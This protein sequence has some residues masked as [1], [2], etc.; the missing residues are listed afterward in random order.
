M[1]SAVA[2]TRRDFT[3]HTLLATA[4]LL[5]GGRVHAQRRSNPIVDGYYA[6]P[7]SRVFPTGPGGD[8]RPTYWIY[9]TFS[10]PYDQ[11]LYLDCFSSP[12]L[13][14]WTKHPRVLDAANIS[15]A[16]RAVWA[17]TILH[18]NDWYYLIFSAND[19]QNDQQ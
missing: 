15:W 12:D 7:E 11:Q 3:T 10:A 8:G 6:D 18:K 2:I 16:R 19:I 9:P 17:P 13:I 5:V 1:Y 4:G 14:T